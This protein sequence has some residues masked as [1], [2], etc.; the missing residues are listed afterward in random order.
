MPPKRRISVP[1]EPPQLKHKPFPD[2]PPHHHPKPTKGTPTAPEARYA[3]TRKKPEF[4]LGLASAAVKCLSHGLVQS[5][6]PGSRKLLHDKLKPEVVSQLAWLI[7]NVGSCGREASDG[8][9]GGSAAASG[10]GRP[11]LSAREKRETKKARRLGEPGVKRELASLGTEVMEMVHEMILGDSTH[12]LL[13]DVLLH[14]LGLTAKC[15]S[16]SIPHASL[17][18]LGRVLVCRLHR[19]N[20]AEGEGATTSS[21]DPLALSI[22]NG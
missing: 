9:G 19:Q 4:F 15:W 3:E 12:H 2:P 11:G 7:L 22:W 20:Q 18:V 8:G 1:L 5:G 14:E 10:G 17:S 16:L 13:H 6:H 21:D